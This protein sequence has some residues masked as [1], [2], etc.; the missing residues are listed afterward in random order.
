MKK[1]IIIL[2]LLLPFFVNAQDYRV[3]DWKTDV[4]NVQTINID[5]F[6]FETDIKDYNDPG[7]IT[8]E[9][10]NYFIDFVARCFKIIDSDETTITVVDLEHINLAPQSNKIGRVYQSIVDADSIFNSIGGVDISVLDDLSKWK[11]VARNNELFG[12]K[13]KELDRRD[14]TG[15]YHI[16]RQ[17]LDSISQEDTTN[18]NKYLIETDT[19]G[20]LDKDNLFWSANKKYELITPHIGGGTGDNVYMT[21]VNS[22][23]SGYKKTSYTNDTGITSFSAI[24]SA[25]TVLVQQFLFDGQLS[26]SILD[27]GGWIV[28][29]YCNVSSIAGVSKFKYEFFVYDDAD[30]TIFSFYS[31][32][33]NNTAFQYNEYTSFQSAFNLGK[34]TYRLGVRVY[35]LT[36]LAAPITGTFRV[37]DG[38]T[39][40]INTPIALRHVRIR[41][42]NEDPN[43]QHMTA[44]DQNAV[45]RYKIDSASYLTSEVD[46]STTNE[47]QDLSRSG[48]TLSLSSDG[49]TVDLSDLVNPSLTG[50]RLKTDHDSLSNLDEKSYNSLTDKPDLTSYRQKS[51][52]DS[53]SALDEKSYN[54]LT[55]KPASLPA[56]DVYAWAKTPTKPTYTKSEVGLGNVDNTSDANKPISTATQTALN[57]LVPFLGAD[58]DVDLGANSISTDTVKIDGVPLLLNTFK[59]DSLGGA[60]NIFYSTGASSQPASGTVNQVIGGNTLTSGYLPYWDGSNLANSDKIKNTTEGI[61]IS[62]N[63]YDGT[64]Q[65]TLLLAEPSFDNYGI[66]ITSNANTGVL[67]FFPYNAGIRR[68]VSLLM[69]NRFSEKVSIPILASSSTR[70]VTASSTG[71]LGSSI[72]SESGTVAT[73]AG[74]IS[75]T[76]LIDGYLP[77]HQNDADGLVNSN[78]YQNASGNVGI[79]TTTPSEALDVNGN[80]IADVLKSRISTGTPPLVVASSTV[81][82][83]LNAGLL[84]GK[85]ASDFETANVNIQRHITN[86]NDT[87]ID[88]EIQDLSR[89]GNT[90]SL[91]G[92]ETSVDLSD[93]VNP[94]LSNYATIIQLRDSI[95]YLKTLIPTVETTATIKTKLGAATN[96]TDGYLLA[97]DWTTF[98]AKQATLVSGTNIKTVNSTSLL[99]SGN[100][101][102]APMVYPSQGLAKSNGTGWD[103]SITDNSALWN[104]AYTMA[105]SLKNDVLDTSSVNINKPN[106]TKFI[107]S[108]TAREGIPVVGDYYGGG[109]V[110]YISPSGTYGYC[111]Y[112]TVIFNGATQTYWSPTNNNSIIASN[113]S[114]GAGINN[115]TLIVSAFGAGNYAAYKCDTFSGGG[116]TDWALPAV[117]D[118]DSIRD[119]LGSAFYSTMDAIYVA[120]DNATNG[121]LY[122]LNNGTYSAYIPKGV[123]QYTYDVIAI[124]RFNITP[125]VFNLNVAE[126][127][128]SPSY[129]E[130]NSMKFVN[131][132]LTQDGEGAVVITP[133]SGGNMNGDQIVAA[134]NANDS[135]TLTKALAAP[136]LIMTGTNYNYLWSQYYNNAY[137]YGIYLTQTP[138]GGYSDLLKFDANNKIFYIPRINLENG[139]YVNSIGTGPATGSSTSKLVTEDMLAKSIQAAGG[140]DMSRSVYDTD[141]DNIVDNSE[142]LGGQLPS[143]YMP[144]VAAGTGSLGGIQVSATDGNLA[145][146]GNYLI[147]KDNVLTTRTPEVSDYI[148]FYDNSA[149]AQGKM[150]LSTLGSLIGGSGGGMVYPGAGIPVSTGSAWGT[151]KTAPSGAIVGTTDSQ[152][153]TNKSV[154]GVTLSTSAGT[155][156]FLAG[157]GTYKAVSGSSKWTADTYG[158]NY[159]SGNVGIG[160]VSASSAHLTSGSFTSS[161][162]V[163]IVGLSNSEIGISGASNT[164][165]G[166]RGT[167]GSSFGGDF[168]GLGCRAT[169]FY[170]SSLNT[171][172]ASSTATGTTGE[173]RFTSDYIYVCVATNTW[174]RTQISTW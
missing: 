146:S 5:T 139:G 91:S 172:P 105:D 72:I 71:Q 41:N 8:R 2:A 114:F 131:C 126:N 10:G 160:S 63:N 108:V 15:I 152:A 100:I 14:T 111:V 157:D 143:Y 27:A 87:I 58:R 92:D 36:T 31:D 127:D 50:Y 24:A 174:K 153:L 98:N 116:Y 169:K 107:Q 18:W 120:N 82:D 66:M 145:M 125:Q 159:Q 93:L 74:T 135:T 149:T 97:T 61:V 32:E 88:N 90:L 101:S 21:N 56:S 23:I 128:G 57:N 170:V 26:T 47:I 102:I 144:N 22:D 49:T 3:I 95:A 38:E 25:D 70:L 113:T 28:R 39:S 46:G 4:L 168:T 171:A 60:G 29:T 119:N 80:L 173:I 51:D 13:I 43:V 55:D 65:N 86:D 166:V 162:I 136:Q 42:P 85:K 54:S 163:G 148:A 89:S 62:C 106:W 67:E 33:I 147:V 19:S 96:S 132:T 124:R 69:F 156:N 155:T 20:I 83:S 133:S 77:L 154:N 122:A 158:I 76:N 138:K 52:H 6:K 134:L 165:I 110:Y 53:L 30:S 99:G 112:P 73:V 109:I 45:N 12:R 164:N 167:S 48:N 118:A 1:L 11:D 81:V 35:F 59:K 9:I 151:S 84:D 123:L 137:D 142:K 40:Y 16:N 79:A 17:L 64:T 78:I 75:A 140:G 104:R 34:S 115:T 150:T 130:I 68:P 121:Y 141:T 7:A 37:G 103:A 117:N 94:D 44:D 129:N 161:T